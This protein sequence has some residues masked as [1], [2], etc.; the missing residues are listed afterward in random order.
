MH[1]VKDEQDLYFLINP[2]KRAQS[3]W[4]AL[5]G[6][7]QLSNWDPATGNQR[8]IAPTS[9]EDDFTRFQVRLPA[10]GSCFILASSVG[11]GHIVATN[12][13]IERFDDAVIHGY[14]AV[15]QGEV[16][17]KHD[18][19][20][21]QLTAPGVASAALPALDGLWEFAAEDASGL[22]IE[23][24]LATP[25]TAGAPAAAYAS[26]DT[27]TNGWL[28]MRNGAWSY[29]LPAEPAQPY[30]LPVWFRCTFQIDHMPS[31]L[32]VIVDG[33]SGAEW[34]LF[35]N[36]QAVT[37]PSRRSTFD[38]QMQ[39]V[40]VGAYVHTGENI[41]AL[42]LVVTAATDGLLDLLKLVGDFSLRPRIEG[43]YAITALKRQLQPTFWTDQGYPFY[44]GRGVYR[45]WFELHADLAGQRIFLDAPVVDDVLEVL[46][47]GE[48]VSV[49][50]WEPYTVEVTRWLQ[51]GENLLEL[52]MANTLINL[53]E[54]VVRP[55]GLCGVPRL[56]AYQDFKFDRPAC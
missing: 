16:V 19:Q 22:V 24:W 21:T 41:L 50:L 39:A 17:V 44:S 4:I 14:G 3:A 48:R 34:R 52:R 28:P 49:C 18:G 33:F 5:P 15:A 56:V 1:R 13:V 6:A 53:L 32:D 38:I 42:R 25:E 12:L 40:A 43:G 36:G 31:Q 20:Q 26:P 55:S 9:L 29:Q 45:C 10:V 2:T 30:P 8:P 54:G 7:L 35:V 51:P 46:V 11:A 27:D 37:S 47:N 23:H